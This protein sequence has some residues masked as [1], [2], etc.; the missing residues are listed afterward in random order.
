[1]SDERVSVLL[2]RHAEP[3]RPGQGNFAENE[4]PLTERGHRDAA[5]LAESLASGLADARVRAVISSP[6]LRAI[7]T[8]EPIAR[9]L[10]I[11]VEIVGDFRERLLSPSDDLPDWRK[12]LERSWRDFDHALPGGESGRAAQARILSVFENLRMKFPSGTLVLGSHGNLIG[13]ALNAFEPKVD[14]EFWAAIPM[15][16]VY[17]LEFAGGRWRVVE[18]PGF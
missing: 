12:H 18:G 11:E 7:Q 10:G 2:V 4:R 16:A 17:R 6:Y 8:V 13:L 3:V 5:E 14:F 9:R 15:P 1:M